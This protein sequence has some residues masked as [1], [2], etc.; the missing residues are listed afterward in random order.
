VR[1]VR[2]VNKTRGGLLGDRVGVADTMWR[3]VRG[4]LGRSRPSTGD[5]LLLS[6]CRAVH[7]YGV[8]YSLD[9]LFLDRH[10]EVIA[11]YPGLAPWKR[12]SWYRRAMYALELPAGTVDAT[13][14]AAGDFLA[15]LPSQAMDEASRGG[16]RLTRD[17]E[18]PAASREGAATLEEGSS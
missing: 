18:S 12:T 1:R 9:V 7:M 10:G 2:I 17:A 3:R 14:T 4:F 13:S 8:S 11:V 5:G 16:F 15:W 6:P